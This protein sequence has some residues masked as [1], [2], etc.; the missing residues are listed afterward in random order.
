[1]SRLGVHLSSTPSPRR[2]VS[3]GGRPSEAAVPS[4]S[5]QR[6]VP[7]HAGAPTRCH[8]PGAQPAAAPPQPAFLPRVRGHEA[9]LGAQGAWFSTRGCCPHGRR[10]HCRFSGEHLLPGHSTRQPRQT[11]L[12]A[13]PELDL[14]LSNGISEGD[15]SIDCNRRTCS[16]VNTA[17]SHSQ[18]AAGG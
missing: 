9:R 3:V 16:D 4:S 15:S 8:P 10:P 14:D 18:W 2:D 1:M 5:A 12:R 11:E 6:R 7:L 13:R 17:S